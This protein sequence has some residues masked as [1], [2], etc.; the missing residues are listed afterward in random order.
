MHAWRQPQD[1]TRSG[2]FHSTYSG[3][4]FKFRAFGLTNQSH[5]QGMQDLLRKP[6]ENIMYLFSAIAREPHMPLIHAAGDK[7]SAATETTTIRFGASLAPEG[8][9]FGHRA[10][11]GTTVH[12]SREDLAKLI[13]V[14]GSSRDPPYIFCDLQPSRGDVLFRVPLSVGIVLLYD[15]HLLPF[16]FLELPEAPHGGMFRRVKTPRRQQRGSAGLLAGPYG[17]LWRHHR[18]VGGLLLEPPFTAQVPGRR[19]LCAR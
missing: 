19:F 11:P 12:V 2:H 8:H 16:L 4:V 6:A 1:V 3:Q 18:Q 17:Q 15:P 5:R 7:T 14:T 10:R 13:V 9:V